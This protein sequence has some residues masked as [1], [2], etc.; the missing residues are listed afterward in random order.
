VV[1]LTGGSDV[2]TL[3][4]DLADSTDWPKA[5]AQVFQVNGGV[6]SLCQAQGG[7]AVDARSRLSG[8]RSLG[9]VIRSR[10]EL[11]KVVGESTWIA[12]DD[13]MQF[14]PRASTFDTGHYPV[15]LIIRE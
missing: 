14:E 5:I 11:T 10:G 13:H 12:R 9:R 3:L 7:G 4:R 8:R 2:Q 1:L 15:A 6:S